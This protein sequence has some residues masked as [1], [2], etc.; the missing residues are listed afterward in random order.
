MKSIKAAVSLANSTGK[1]LTKELVLRTELTGRLIND[2]CWQNQ[3]DGVECR[4]KCRE[5]AR[6][7]M[8]ADTSGRRA[9]SQVKHASKRPVRATLW[10]LPVRVNSHVSMYVDFYFFHCFHCLYFL[11][12]SL[13]FFDLSFL[14]SFDLHISTG[15]QLF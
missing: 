13:I 14:S 7:C 9:F 2:F 6:I 3:E 12:I 11:V 10:S 1:S 8:G 4:L 5:H 15:S